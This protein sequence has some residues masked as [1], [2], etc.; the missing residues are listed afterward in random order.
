MDYIT[1]N[2]TP[3]RYFRNF[4]MYYIE[5]SIKNLGFSKDK[6]TKK[7]TIFCKNN[8]E[9][10]KVRIDGSLFYKVKVSLIDNELIKN[11]FKNALEIV[12]DINQGYDNLLKTSEFYFYWP[13]NFNPKETDL[14]IPN[15]QINYCDSETGIISRIYS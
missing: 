10:L 11:I 15:Y 12:K 5:K 2:L 14:N 13:E 9:I 7:Y 1:L 6:V 3:N 8:N 4:D